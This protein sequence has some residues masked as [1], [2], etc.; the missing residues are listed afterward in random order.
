MS[1]EIIEKRI[2]ESIEIKSELLN[3]TEIQNKINKMAEIICDS[4]KQG[5]K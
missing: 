4:I 1:V 3:N 5:A 2:S